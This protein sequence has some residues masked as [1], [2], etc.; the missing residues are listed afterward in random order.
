MDINTTAEEIR[1][2]VSAFRAAEIN[3]DDECLE[4]HGIKGM[5]WGVRSQETLRKYGGF[6]K[7]K[8]LGKERAEQRNKKKAQLKRERDE[9]GMAKAKYDKLREKTMKSHDPRVVA[10][11]MHTLSDEELTKKISR[12]RL[13]GQM[14]GLAEERSRQKANDLQRKY[15]AVKK[16]PVYELA[17]D[18]IKGAAR[19]TIKEVTKGVI[20]DQLYSSGAA[21]VLQ[22]KINIARDEALGRDGSN[23]S[24][25]F[26]F[27]LGSDSGESKKGKK[28][29]G[30]VNYADIANRY[31]Q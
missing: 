12:L 11:G 3:E 7:V 15:D 27:D 20:V 10:K 1:D 9:Y 21:P 24:S 19:D 5:K 17:V 14:S 4:H 22:K 2:F 30:R 8:Q 28:K 16:N 18:P 13:E 26:P 29:K 31:L 25:P 6:S 23:G